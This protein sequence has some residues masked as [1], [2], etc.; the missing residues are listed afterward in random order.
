MPCSPSLLKGGNLGITSGSVSRDVLVVVIV[1][2][3]IV[4]D[5]LDA[6]ET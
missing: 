6:E 3:M 4:G 5:S 2:G 1:V